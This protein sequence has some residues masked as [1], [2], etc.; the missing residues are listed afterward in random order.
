MYIEEIMKPYF[1]KKEQFEKRYIEERNFIKIRL[2]RLRDKKEQE[3]AEYLQNEVLG[4]SNF[5]GYEAVRKDLEQAY[6]KKEQELELELQNYN[7]SYK[8]DALKL[9]QIKYD[10]RKP[11]ISAK[12]EIE[13]KL[14]E[15]QINLNIVMLKLSKFKHLYNSDNIATNGEE[16]KKLFEERNYIIDQNNILRKDLEK[17]AEYLNIEDLPLKE[18]E[19]NNLEE[20]VED[21]EQEIEESN[22]E[23]PEDLEQETEEQNQELSEDENKGEEDLEQTA[24]II[25]P[26][27]EDENVHEFNNVVELLQTVYT[28]ILQLMKDENKLTTINLKSDNGDAYLTSTDSNGK[29]QELDGE[30]DFDSYEE[31]IEMPNGVCLNQKDVFKALKNYKKQNKGRIFKVKGFEDSM[32]INRKSIKALKKSL[33]DCSIIKLLR[34]KKLGNFDIKRVYGKQ[35]SEEYSKYVELGKVKTN[36]PSGKYINAKEFGSNLSLLFAKKKKTWMEKLTVRASETYLGESYI[37][38]EE[39]Q[40]TR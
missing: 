6:L 35:K 33:R 26:E 17:I 4:K 8:E 18:I 24:E 9:N 38:D 31:R 28:D 19:D 39:Q 40:K 13:L 15:N 1:D 36:A 29:E 22:Q 11:L 16:L 30:I 10:L 21:L 32:E 5:V 25:E 20:K 14:E 3:I 23:L 27:K 7:K 37:I 34:E 2:E 12:K